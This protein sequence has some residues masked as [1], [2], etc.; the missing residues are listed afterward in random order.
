MDHLFTVDLAAMPPAEVEVFTSLRPTVR[1]LAAA[2]FTD[3]DLLAVHQEYLGRDCGEIVTRAARVADEAGRLAGFAGFMQQDSRV[4]VTQNGVVGD[5]CMFS[6]L[7]HLLHG[8]R[9]E[10]NRLVRL[11]EVLETA[12]TSREIIRSPACPTL[13]LGGALLRGGV[14]RSQSSHRDPSPTCRHLCS[15]RRATRLWGR[16][17]DAS[18]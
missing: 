18:V 1:A 11:A 14:R 13:R 15:G 12:M 4:R 9:A 17:P 6:N 7:G 10:R 2:T 8:G 3:V 5:S 16:P